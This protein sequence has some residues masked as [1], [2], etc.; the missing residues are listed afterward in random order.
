MTPLP[1]LLPS[2]DRLENTKRTQL[3][4]VVKLCGYFWV[5][6]VCVYDD[7]ETI[8]V[9]MVELFGFDPMRKI[10]NFPADL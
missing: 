2:F 5:M 8:I 7:D 4:N 9:V 6:C 10:T 1:R 3:K